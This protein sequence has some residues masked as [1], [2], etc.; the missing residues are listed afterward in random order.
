MRVDNTDA[1]VLE[2]SPG[3]AQLNSSPE[4]SHL[5]HRVKI[6]P[7]KFTA[8]PH[9]YGFISSL[10][11]SLSLSLYLF[12]L[13][14]LFLFSCILTFYLPSFFLHYNALPLSLSLSL[15]LPLSLSDLQSTRL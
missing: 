6:R 3:P 9:H 8:R 15:S 10:T 4:Y 2:E 11:L 14:S 7:F 5:Q 13:L 12:L 1:A